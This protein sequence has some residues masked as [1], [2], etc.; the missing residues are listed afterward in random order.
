MSEIGRRRSFRPFRLLARSCKGLLVRSCNPQ[1]KYIESFVARKPTISPCSILDSLPT[2]ILVSYIS[3]GILQGFLTVRS[4]STDAACMRMANPA[5]QW[6]TAD[7][8][9]LSA[10][11]RLRQG[12]GT[13]LISRMLREGALLLSLWALCLPCARHLVV[14]TRAAH[15]PYGNFCMVTHASPRT[16][17]CRREHF[18][19]GRALV[20]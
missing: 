8:L 2:S 9:L 13:R 7:L 12:S 20:L 6:Y 17:P 16:R 11:R 5:A 1:T 14:V 3:P 15:K 4:S 10:A 19:L 18:L